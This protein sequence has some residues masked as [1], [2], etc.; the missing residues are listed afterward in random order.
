MFLDSRLT[1]NFETFRLKSTKN[2]TSF[3]DVH[4]THKFKFSKERLE[5]F[6]AKYVFYIILNLLAL[7]CLL[8]LWL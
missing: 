3:K 8:F 4:L 2:S 7:F 6:A 5:I 1:K